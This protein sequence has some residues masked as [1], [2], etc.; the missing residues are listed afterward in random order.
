[1]KKTLLYI[2]LII[3]TDLSAQQNDTIRGDLT[4]LESFGEPLLTAD[5][6]IKGTEFKTKTDLK[7]QIRTHRNR[8]RDLH[9][10]S[11]FLGV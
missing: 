1:M 10:C 9:P 4:D 8:T 3:M 5:L 11:G 7:R 2:A 6:S